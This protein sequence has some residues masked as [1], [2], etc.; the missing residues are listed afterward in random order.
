M[1]KM[2]AAAVVA[3]FS[4]LPSVLYAAGKCSP[5]NCGLCLEPPP[6]NMT[7]YWVCV[8]DSKACKDC[9]TEQKKQFE[10]MRSKVDETLKK[11]D[12]KSKP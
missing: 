3:V 9:S 6:P 12:G 1:G 10:E 11:T 5:P 8:T 7:A 4:A 2:K